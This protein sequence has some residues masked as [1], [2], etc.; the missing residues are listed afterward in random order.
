MLSSQ[1]F[2]ISFCASWLSNTSLSFAEPLWQNFY[3]SCLASRWAS[4]ILSFFIYYI[5][6]ITLNWEHSLFYQIF[7][8]VPHLGEQP[9]IFAF[10][11]CSILILRRQMDTVLRYFKDYSI[12]CMDCSTSLLKVIKMHFGH[13]PVKLWI[14]LISRMCSRVQW[15]KIWNAFCKT[16]FA[17]SNLINYSNQTNS[18]KTQ[19]FLKEKNFKYFS[20]SFYSKT[21]F[22]Y[23]KN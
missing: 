12:V 6:G 20:V 9:T 16:S 10:Q 15:K 13:R 17:V 23:K 21:S 1:S 8:I 19:L 22:L 4:T 14:S 2:I 11:S 3:F 7:H 5:F 18:H